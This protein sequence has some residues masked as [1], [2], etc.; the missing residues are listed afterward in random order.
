VA[1]AAGTHT[2]DCEV[3]RSFRVMAAATTLMLLLTAAAFGWFLLINNPARNKAADVTRMI[4]D[5]HTAMVD[6]ETGLRAYAS[7]GDLNFLQPYELGVATVASINAKLPAEISGSRMVGELLDMRIAQDRWLQDWGAMARS[8]R[9]V[10]SLNAGS[11]GRSNA[12][13]A[14]FFETGKVEF[15]AYRVSEA[16]LV[17]DA[18]ANWTVARNESSQVLIGVLASLV[19]VGG[20][21]FIFIV[22]RRRDLQKRVVGPIARLLDVVQ[23]VAAG[24]FHGAPEMDG[25]TEIVELRDGLAD[26]ITS[27][28]LQ[29][30]ALSGRAEEADQMAGRLRQVL[31]F[32]REVSGSLTLRYVLESAASSARTIANSPRVR[33][34]LVD[35]DNGQ[36]ALGYD[37]A[38]DRKADVPDLT[39][40]LGVGAVGRAAQYGDT[41][42]S[43]DLDG[44]DGVPGASGPVLAQPLIVGARVT[45]VIEITL[46]ANVDRLTDAGMEVLETIAGHAATA[47]EAA[48]LH[49]RT[50]M[51][52]VSDAL[53]G[54]SNRRRLDEELEMETERALRYARPL[55]LVMVDVDH[56]KAINDT[57]GHARGDAVLQEVAA[58]LR[59]QM[60]TCDT[61]YRY[62]GEEFVV[63]A[64]ETDAEGGA[65][66]AERLRETI[67]HRFAR[68]SSGKVTISLGVSSVPEH[69]VSPPAL[70]QS[71]DSALYAAKR[72]GRNRVVVAAPAAVDST[73]S[74]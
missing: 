69:A 65:V 20:A 34:W 38:V 33:L 61:V 8:P 23:D 47:I 18:R 48:R 45:G 72:G 29:Q 28:A 4:E 53:T 43:A 54:L 66:L 15:D 64:R 49:Q 70:V 32:A 42:Y 44:D 16:K 1:A 3:S 68:S 46:P 56:F 55:T 51:L 22:R 50:A 74:R 12:K 41:N 21:K 11:S 57:Y 59:D 73:V 27:L 24:R 7:T 14:T 52:S 26:M 35:E 58:A 19:L 31:A 40:Q 5:A 62:G 71:A 67:E 10:A 2:L 36:L 13:L 9:F 63:L 60:R 25:P 37:T 6:E 17:A 30:R 39:V